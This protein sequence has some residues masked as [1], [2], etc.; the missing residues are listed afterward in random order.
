VSRSCGAARTGLA[1]A[2]TFIKK[3]NKMRATLRVRPP[4]PLS[5][6]LQPPPLRYNWLLGYGQAALDA[7]NAQ[8]Q[9][10][11]YKLSGRGGVLVAAALLEGSDTL[12]WF[13]SADAAEFREYIPGE[14]P[15]W[16]AAQWG[17]GSTAAYSHGNL[18][19]LSLVQ[20]LALETVAGQNG[21]ESTLESLLEQ[22]EVALQLE[23]Y[24]SGWWACVRT[25]GIAASAPASAAAA[26][27]ATGEVGQ[28]ADAGGGKGKKDAGRPLLLLTSRF[29]LAVQPHLRYVS[30][31]RTKI[32]TH[33]LW[34]E[35]VSGIDSCSAQLSG[36]G[37]C[38]VYVSRYY[39]LDGEPQARIRVLRA[40]NWQEL[41]PVA[42]A[43][44]EKIVRCQE[45]RAQRQAAEALAA[46]QAEAQAQG[47]GA[48]K[49]ATPS[50]VEAS[51][52]AGVSSG[53][54]Y[55]LLV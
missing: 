7:L 22:E 28:V 10:L 4:F 33:V 46:A 47:Q 36:D 50:P 16:L 44:Q 14:V 52:E 5:H 3:F 42:T 18:E 30:A 11:G 25:H 41:L 29:L 54:G 53:N 13:A 45:R 6:S 12:R 55:T 1:K 38:C 8:P 34:A 31:G 2:Y 20:Q 24:D 51:G 39:K 15:V 49:V 35:K 17:G 37:T 48:A 43:L 27:A 26:A 9:G 19:Q 32:K 21:R 40:A 23:D